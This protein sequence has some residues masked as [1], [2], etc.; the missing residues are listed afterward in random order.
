MKGLGLTQ[1]EIFNWSIY[2]SDVQKTLAGFDINSLT[3]IFNKRHEVIH[4]GKR[5]FQSQGEVAVVHLF[6]E[7]IT[8]NLCFLA[9]QVFKVPVDLLNPPEAPQGLR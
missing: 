8:M 6:L 1:P 9:S 3:T 5:P 7:K 4:A 2:T